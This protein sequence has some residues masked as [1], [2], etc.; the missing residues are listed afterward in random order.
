MLYKNKTVYTLANTLREIIFIFTMDLNKK[1]MAMKWAYICLSA[2]LSASCLEKVAQRS[3]RIIDNY[4]PILWTEFIHPVKVFEQFEYTSEVNLF[5]V[6]KYVFMPSRQACFPQ[7]PEWLRCSHWIWSAFWSYYGIKVMFDVNCCNE[8][9][10]LNN[11][12]VN[13]INLLHHT[14]LPMT[15]VVHFTSVYFH[16]GIC[17]HYV[18]SQRQLAN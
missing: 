7:H 15:S 16:L 9:C 18:A 5:F 17:N 11:D 6:W 4:R 3:F 1:N 8:L 2:Q 10:I 14:V 12:C 13:I